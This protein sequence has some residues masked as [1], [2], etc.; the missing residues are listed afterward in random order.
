MFK[1]L[2]NFDKVVLPGQGSLNNAPVFKSIG[3]L[4]GLRDFVIIK[5]PILGI[6]VGMQLFS[7]FGDEDGGSVGLGW[8]GKS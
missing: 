6:C 8:I 7:S 2:N 1:D 3:V 5:K 4:D